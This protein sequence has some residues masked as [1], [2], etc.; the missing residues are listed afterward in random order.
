MRMWKEESSVHGHLVSIGETE[1]KVMAVMEQ[2]Q[3]LPLQQIVKRS[4][5]PYHSVVL[6]V[7]RLVRYGLASCMLSGER[8]V[9]RLES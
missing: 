9:F 5:E 1:R 8:F 4:G 3:G 7:A 2:G 6:V